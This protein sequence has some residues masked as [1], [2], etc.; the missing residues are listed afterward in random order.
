MKVSK[1]LT[2]ML[3]GLAKSRTNFLLSAVI[4]I[5]VYLM[6]KKYVPFDNYLYGF[7]FRCWYIQVLNLWLFFA[8][9]IFLLGRYG[10]FGLEREALEKLNLPDF[11]IHRT[12]VD[13]LIR[14]MPE[15]YNVT[16]CFRR[17]KEILQVYR[18]G[19][20]VIR[21]NEELSRRDIDLVNRGHLLLNSLR[22]I[23]PVIGFL[24]TVI[25][26]SLGMVKFPEV[27]E[28]ALDIEQLR[29]VLK[30][31][32]ASLSVAF[33]TTLLAL[34]FTIV[35]ILLSS[36]LRHREEDLVTE[37]DENARLLIGKLKVETS[38]QSPATPAGTTKKMLSPL[39]EILKKTASQNVNF[40]KLME[41]HT[42]QLVDKLEE[43]QK[44]LQ[45]LRR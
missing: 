45:R 34:G 35:I 2:E 23:I 19:E 22:Q 10:A 28:S 31:F 15:K 30:D 20:D 14:G 27:A 29:F 9:I 40:A 12:D 38:K 43:I 39:E 36:L 17:L 41:Q 4:T 3:R 26:L 44:G 25:G 24:G 16:F 5:I 8:G 37:V 7:F 1:R 42:K 11:D 13:D 33:D 18:Y 32:A 6:M 21:L